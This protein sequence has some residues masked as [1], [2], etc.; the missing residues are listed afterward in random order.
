MT[1]PVLLSRRTLLAAAALPAALPGAAHARPRATAKT[2]RAPLP[3]VV[4]DPGHGG[5]D[6]GAIGVSGTYEKHVAFAAAEELRRQLTAGGRCR[7][8][9][10]RGRDTF[11]PLRH[12]VEIAQ[13]K[14]AVLFVSMHAD[15]L[16]DPAVH[17]ASV[18]TLADAAS[19][20]QTA[21]LARRENSAD[22]FG[23]PRFRD[24]PPDVAEILS[25]LVR[26]E[27]RAGSARMARHVVGALGPR[28][29]LL[30][31][32]ARHA[33]FMVLRAAEIPSVLVEMG[34]M[35]NVRDEAALRRPDH[36][37]RIAA[38]LRSAVEG[39]LASRFPAAHIASRLNATARLLRA[40]DRMTNKGDLG[41]VGPQDRLGGAAP[42]DQMLA[43]TEQSPRAR[44]PA[45]KGSPF[46]RF[47]RRVI[48]LF[49]LLG[50]LGGL[51]AGAFAWHTY[52]R[53]AAELPSLDGLRTYQP[54]VMSRVYAGDDRLMAEFATERRIFVPIS[55]IP[56]TLKQA[57]ISAEDQNFWTHRGVDPLAIARAGVSDI[58]SYGSGRRPIGASTITQ[59]VAKNM[60]LGNEVSIARKVK[61]LILALR[62]DDSMTK[63]H[64][65][66]LYLNEIYLG[67]QSY[68]VA[69]AAAAYFNKTLDEL[70]LPESAFL[71]ALP[72]APNNYNPFRNADAAKARRDWVLD[73]MA[74]D[75]AITTVQAQAAKAT[76]IQPAAFRRQEPVPGGE[77]YAEEVRR[78]L[79]DRFGADLTTT[80]GYS[81]RTSLDPAMQAAADKALRAGM[82]AYDRARG[83]WRGP[84]GHLAGNTAMSEGWSNRLAETPRPPGMLAEWRLAVAL[85]V[86]SRDARV[87]WIDRTGPGGGNSRTG[88][89]SLSDLAW[90]RPRHGTT[91]GPSPRKMA[92]ILAVG[93]LVMV[94]PAPDAK[95]AKRADRVLLRQIPVVQGAL[96][97]LEPQ[98]GR[99]LAMVGGWS[100]DSSQFNRATQ[101][102][103]QPGSSFKP[104]VYLTALE[105][106]LSPSQRV[107]DAPFELKTAQGIWKPN[108]YGMTFG[109][110]TPMRIALEKSLNL[111]TVRLADTVGIDAVA[112]NA[113]AF[114]VVD[115]MPKVLSASLGAVETTVLRQAS[116]YA[117]LA[118]NG[119]EVLPSLVDGV[120]DRDGKLI[121][122][123]SGLECQGCQDPS[124][125][126]TIV[127]TR[128]QIADPASTFQLVTMMQGVVQKGTGYAAGV[129]LGR[130]IAG[131]TGTSQDYNDAWFVGFTP[132]L[133]TAVWIGFD[134]NTSLG[135]KE[136]GGGLAAPIWHDYMA[137]ALK[138]RPNLQFTMPDGLK[139]ATWESGFGSRTDAFK[140]DQVPGASQGVVGGGVTS[141][142]T[143]VSAAPGGP[144]VGIDSGVGGLY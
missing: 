7:I 128:R 89:L 40:V 104:M 114:H 122:R 8:A 73:R 142:A 110:P 98:T 119:R 88:T 15:A 50:L 120:Q 66:E 11:L 90:A 14:G 77:W 84:V 94:E 72:K 102:E 24:V 140:P 4:L 78:Q 13:N 68:G 48:G 117:G 18:Y 36:R 69:A 81:I 137:T 51:A 64:V 9:L 63:E 80:G 42:K 138:N 60:L 70:T 23:G 27:T 58:M 121:W 74:D 131:K 61:E 37:A 54:K 82:M 87:G 108:N 103:R 35:S 39:F 123:P 115:G 25:S 106:G 99:V 92:D 130:A 113:I 34:F 21:A 1:D 139:M 20:A 96:V 59:Q 12:R 53:Y 41:G 135:E 100:F 52:Q 118:M 28:I 133:V 107:L 22:R 85:S 44:R 95:D 5:K 126:P 125:P 30:A 93:D 56:D 57:F 144:G 10:T 29:G 46:W 111:V 47:V 19:D 55:A 101:A 31:N 6:P 143:E 43:E 16:G 136:T 76:P 129:G 71:A 2:S 26:A 33:H 32:P 75:R 109:G 116:A 83:G 17:G 132:D 67:Q 112:Q 124:K 38:A 86:D 134:N 105:A 49:L 3:L 65:L 91:R 79:V 141:D 45:R 62:I 127:D 97:S